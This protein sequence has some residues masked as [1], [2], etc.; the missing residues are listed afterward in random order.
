VKKHPRKMSNT[1]GQQAAP[2]TTQQLVSNTNALN[3]KINDLAAL[4]EGLSISD[5]VKETIEQQLQEMQVREIRL[6]LKALEHY[7]GKTRPLRSWLTEANLHL[8]NANIVDES[9]KVRFIG[10]HLKGEAWDWFEP[11]A[12]ERNSK[13]RVQW[14]DRTTRILSG[15]E[16]LSKAMNQV[17]GDIDE[18]KTA[19]RKIQQLRQTTSVRS[20]ITEFQTITAN[21]DWDS[22]A[23]NDKFQEGLKQNIR[24][25]LVF[26]PTG[27]ENLEQLF[28][29]AQRIDREQWSRKERYDARG[30]NYF[31]KKQAV[32][33]DREGDVIMAGAKVNMEEA[34]KTG[35]CFKCGMKGHRAYRCQQGKTP[36]NTQ[37]TPTIG[38]RIRM[39]RL[40]ELP[41]HAISQTIRKPGTESN[42]ETREEGSDVEEIEREPLEVSTLFQ[43]L[44]LHDLSTEESD[45]DAETEAIDWEQ[46]EAQLNTGECSEETADRVRDWLKIFRKNEMK[47]DHQQNKEG[48][49]AQEDTGIQQ[50]AQNS[51][52]TAR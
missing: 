9:A 6:K 14:S 18:R 12:R 26:F 8:E 45:S 5:D 50:N 28:E 39:V 43:G 22:E 7:D 49:E 11:I 41:Q 19:A 23:L 47:D 16:E 25:A 17:F 34:K 31:R 46:V 48:L 20:Y 1:S 40:E 21:L 13:P 33:R 15:Y 10:G 32:K 36:R 37:G 51:E 35:A 4:V 52:T 2:S 3:R 27:H 24:D 44:T 30:L 29:R 42:D 38:N